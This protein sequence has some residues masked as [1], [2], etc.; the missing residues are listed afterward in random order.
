MDSS[1][2]GM[3]LIMI[4]QVF[5]PMLEDGIRVLIYAGDVDFICNWS[6]CAASL[7]FSC[8]IPSNDCRMGN[9]AWTLALPWTGKRAFNTEADHDWTYSTAGALPQCFFLSFLSSLSHAFPSCSV[10]RDL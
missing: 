4:A 9:K 5:T 8:L 6:D 1:A 7:L 10:Q 3:G 2:V